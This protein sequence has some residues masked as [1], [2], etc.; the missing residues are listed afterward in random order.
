MRYL[1]LI[2]S[3]LAVAVV[4]LAAVSL[5]QRAGQPGR[6][7]MGLPAPVTPPTAEQWHDQAD[8]KTALQ[9]L[10]EAHDPASRSRAGAGLPQELLAQTAAPAPAAKPVG[11][12]AAAPVH[13]PRVTVVLETG[14]E[15][16]AVVD[17]RLV[18]VGDTVEGGLRVESI[19]VEEVT[20]IRGDGLRVRVAVAG[21]QRPAPKAATDRAAGARQ[22]PVERR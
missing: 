14:T 17:G 3:A 2:L 16:K 21:D 18:H 5:S 22:A 4:T 11:K 1:A 13:Q 8:L 9:A 19:Q 20:F 15:G 12:P 10:T 6:P 7:G